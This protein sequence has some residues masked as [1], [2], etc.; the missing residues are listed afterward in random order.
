MTP[1]TDGRKVR[2]RSPVG[3]ATSKT[4]Y[5]A[6]T[7]ST[8]FRLHSS[9]RIDERARGMRTAWIQNLLMSRRSGRRCGPRTGDAIDRL[10]HA[11]RFVLPS[12]ATVIVVGADDD[13]LQRMGR[14]RLRRFD[15]PADG[16]QTL[17][18][19]AD[20]AEA[21]ARLEAHRAEE[22][23]YFL[24]IPSTEASFFR[25]YEAFRNDLERRYRVVMRDDETAVIFDV[26]RS[27]AASE[28][29]DAAFR[30][31][32][33]PDGLPLPPPEAI[34]LVMGK[35]GARPFYDSGLLG[36]QGIRFVLER[37][38][39][40]IER[41]GSVLD[42]GC[43]CGRVIRHWHG[44]RGPCVFGSD[45][46]PY[47]VEWCKGALPFAHFT[48]NGLAPQLAFDAS[49]FD[50]IYAKSVFTHLSEELQDA[51][52]AELKRVAK[53]GALLVITLNGETS[54]NR[55]RDD[56]PPRR[57]AKFESGARLVLREHFEG[58]NACAAF[59]PETYVRTVFADRLKVVDHLPGDTNDS[60]QDT[61]LFQ[62]PTDEAVG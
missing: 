16:S 23:D 50:L 57:R 60:I 38:D 52:L 45:Y 12:R 14:P 41:F 19:A 10:R 36:A 46:N 2:A 29:D 8:Q 18:P 49:S 17:L 56:L 11:L 44:L 3:A 39:L 7:G 43:G 34:A 47:L 13:L 48:T 53:P 62:V 1:S 42:F 32:G 27:E 35:Y 58:T 24:V 51:W 61:Y 40:E 33:A 20:S 15:Q 22:G 31:E 37:N 26:R 25:R 30:R 28:A 55:R 6:T 4:I 9:I 54:F 59:H 5:P 21:I